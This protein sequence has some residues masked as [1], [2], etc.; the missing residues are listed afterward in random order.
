MPQRFSKD[1]AGVEIV[2]DDVIV[3]GDETTHDEQLHI[4]LERASMKGLKHNRE[5]Y[6]IRHKEVP[7]VGHL[8][9]AEGLNIDLR[10]VQATQ[11]MPEP[12]SKEDVKRCFGFVQYLS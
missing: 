6:K 2:I 4:F 9:T 12:R 1:L 11:E 3:A 5:K 7:Y 8:L 10:K